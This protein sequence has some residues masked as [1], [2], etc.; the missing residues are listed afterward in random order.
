M[1]RISLLSLLCILVSCQNNNSSSADRFKYGPIELE[2]NPQ[3]Q[4]AYPVIQSRCVN[5]HTSTIHDV[6]ASYTTSAQ[7]ISAGLVIKQ[8]PN[9]SRFIRYIQNSGLSP[10]TMPLNDG[11]LPNDEYQ[12]LVD[13]VNGIP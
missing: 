1:I 9:N 5:C 13:W 2:N 4:A 8:D 7:Y 10:A 12:I 6:W 3:F 11:P